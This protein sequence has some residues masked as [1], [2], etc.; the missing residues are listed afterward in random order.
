MEQCEY[1][2]L[3]ELFQFNKVF[4]ELAC[5]SV[6]HQVLEAVQQVHTRGIA[7]MDLKENNILISY[8]PKNAGNPLTGGLP[9]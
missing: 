7:H 5:F 9:I 1:G 4:S 2:S 3:Q 8:A 6:F